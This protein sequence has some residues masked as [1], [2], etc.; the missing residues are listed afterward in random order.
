MAITR[1]AG[2]GVLAPSP[3]ARERVGVR[4]HHPATKLKPKS[5]TNNIFYPLPRHHI[6][7]FSM[8]FLAMHGPYGG[9]S[10][11]KN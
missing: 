6:G 11:L 4:V 5:Q 2:D 8:N 1:Q 9:Y 10:S 3:A 7:I